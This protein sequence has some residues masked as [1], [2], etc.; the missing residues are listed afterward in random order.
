MYILHNKEEVIKSPMFTKK[1]KETVIEKAY[2]FINDIE[3]NMPKFPNYL[4]KFISNNISKCMH[5]LMEI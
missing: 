3:K 5:L 2:E 4:R 1:F